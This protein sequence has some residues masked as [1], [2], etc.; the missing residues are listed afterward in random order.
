MIETESEKRILTYTGPVSA[1]QKE[2][3]DR[4]GNRVTGVPSKCNG[5]L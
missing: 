3:H 2:F 1:F 4:N 5:S